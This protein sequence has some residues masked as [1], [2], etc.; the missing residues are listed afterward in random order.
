MKAARDLLTSNV[1]LFDSDWENA[2]LMAKLRP[3]IV[4]L[5]TSA[6]LL[7]LKRTAVVQRFVIKE[8]LTNSEFIEPEFQELL[9]DWWEKRKTFYDR[10][11][12]VTGE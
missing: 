7:G 8:A 6:G 3:E 9:E 12:G 2:V 11:F 4:D 5:R 10:L 1:V